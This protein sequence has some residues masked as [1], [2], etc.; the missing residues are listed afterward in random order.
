VRFAHRS[1]S[2]DHRHGAYNAAYAWTGPAQGS[3]PNRRVRSAHR[4]D[5]RQPKETA[6]NTVQRLLLT[7]LL[8]LP[9]AGW[10]GDGQVVDIQV[11]GMSCPFCVY[12]VEKRLKGLPG[13]DSASVDLK[14]SRARIV[15]QPGQEPDLEKIRKAI[16]DAGFTP[17]EVSAGTP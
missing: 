3:M 8:A 14:L 11:K 4:T 2:A 6:M 12:G 15:M 5:Q 10:A 9:L 16:T 13:V 7:L 1:A 17:G